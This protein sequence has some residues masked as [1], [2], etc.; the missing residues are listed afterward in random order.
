MTRRFF[1]G[2]FASLTAASTKA[3][4]FTKETIL[5]QPA[6]RQVIVLQDFPSAVRSNLWF[7][8][9]HEDGVRFVIGTPKREP[10]ASG[11]IAPTG[12]GRRGRDYGVLSVKGLLSTIPLQVVFSSRKPFQLLGYQEVFDRPYAVRSEGS[13]GSNFT[14]SQPKYQGPETDPEVIRQILAT[15]ETPRRPAGLH[16][17]QQQPKEIC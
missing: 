6:H 13:Y 14:Y 17:P 5:R 10:V 7:R 4:A 16:L 3:V 11:M 8:I 1:S 15:G 2:I 9:R 12:E